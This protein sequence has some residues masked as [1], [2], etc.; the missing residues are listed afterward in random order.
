MYK[1]E[2]VSCERDLTRKEC[3]LIKDMSDVL[4]IDELTKDGDLIIDVDYTAKIKIHNDKIEGDVKE[5]TKMV[6]V[7]KNGDRYVSGSESLMRSYEDIYEEMNGSD[8]VWSIKVIRKESKNYK[9]GTFLTC[10][11]V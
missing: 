7:D 9:G 3:V 10:V 2:L 5:Y 1:A 8:E 6:F 11:I 4:S